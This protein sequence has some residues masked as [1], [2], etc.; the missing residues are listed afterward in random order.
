MP[1]HGIYFSKINAW[2]KT[3]RRI[4][5]IIR[6]RGYLADNPRDARVI[7]NFGGDNMRDDE[8]VII[9][10]KNTSVMYDKIKMNRKLDE[11]Q[12]LHPKTYYYPF[13]NLPNTNK[14]CVIKK[15]NGQM[16]NHQIFTK[17]DRIE[18]SSLNSSDYIQEFIPFETEYRVVVDHRG[19]F[20]VTE[21]IGQAKLRNSKS[22][23]FKDRF[24][25]ELYDLGSQVCNRMGVDFS[26]LD[27]GL[28]N[29][30][31]Y[32]I[33]LNSAPSLSERNCEVFA[34]H[35]INLCGDRY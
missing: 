1:K 11:I 31:Y 14:E 17:F 6:E 3:R 21:K 28:Y 22:C 30:D 10:N 7:V 8:D 27:V 32:I 19:V 12:V 18:K 29:G 20:R 24:I 2:F 15:R 5:K 4:E 25:P 23:V 33:E 9:L 26:G 16:G 34:A 13:A 35:L